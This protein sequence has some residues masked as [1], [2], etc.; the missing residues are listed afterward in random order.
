MKDKLLY[1]EWGD[2]V[3]APDKWM[4][5]EDLVDWIESGGWL[6]KQVGF[7]V[8]ETKD[9]I[10]LAAMK[11]DK[12]KYSQGFYGHVHKVPKGWIIKRKLCKRL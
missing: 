10:V 1:I 11:V 6:V 2:A 5:D 9:Y 4:A 8:G 7:L 12:S 3:S